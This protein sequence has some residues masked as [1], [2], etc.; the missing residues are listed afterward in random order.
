MAFELT[1]SDPENQD[2]QKQSE[3]NFQ[4]C[5][6]QKQYQTEFQKLNNS[7]PYFRNPEIESC[8]LENKFKTKKHN[9]VFHKIQ[10]P[11]QS[12]LQKLNPK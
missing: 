12:S 3:F 10:I 2:L 1:T 8:I 6:N 5:F 11:N 4:S 7:Q 9:S